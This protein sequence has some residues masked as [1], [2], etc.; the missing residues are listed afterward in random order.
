MQEIKPSAFTIHPQAA[1]GQVTLAVA[2]LQRSLLFYEQIIG[3]QRLS[4][5]DHGAVLGVN[6]VPLLYLTEK[7]GATKQPDFSTGLYHVAILLP[8]RADLAREI[9]HLIDVRYP[10]QG[11]ADHLVSEAFYLADPDGNGLE[12]YRDRPRSEWQ[13]D[14]GTVRMASDPIDFDSFFGEIKDNPQTWAGL[15]AGTRI[16]HMH[17]RVGD[18]TRAEAFYHGLLGFDVV[19]HWNGAIFLSAGGYHHHLGANTWQ[20]RNAPP[21]PDTSVGLQA[22]TVTLPDQTE[23]ERLAERLTAEGVAFTREGQALVVRDPWQN[24]VRLVVG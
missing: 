24:Q 1:I 13:W 23:L 10:I 9:Q 2:D 3:F 21:A 11:Y 8:S 19:A 4:Q 17:L 18:T 15:P 6:G 22:F 20:S 5:T 12:L 16:G 14:G 7:P